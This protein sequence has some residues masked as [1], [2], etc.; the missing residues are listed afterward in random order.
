MI[1]ERWGLRLEAGLDFILLLSGVPPLFGNL[2]KGCEEQTTT[3]AK[4]GGLSTPQRTVK[5][6]VAPVEMTMSLGGMMT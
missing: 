3:K 2:G 4:Y 5:L 6:S 1:N